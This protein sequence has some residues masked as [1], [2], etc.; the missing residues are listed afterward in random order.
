MDLDLLRVA[1]MFSHCAVKRPPKAVGFPPDNQRL[2]SLNT[3]GERDKILDVVDV[4]PTCVP[5]ATWHMTVHVRSE[6]NR[7]FGWAP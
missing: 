7:G 3:M 5:V 4:A 6:I 1:G 2:S